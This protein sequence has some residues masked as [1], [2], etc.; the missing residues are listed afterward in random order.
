MGYVTKEQA[1]M[2]DEFTIVLLQL[3]EHAGNVL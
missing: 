2:M 3:S 1:M